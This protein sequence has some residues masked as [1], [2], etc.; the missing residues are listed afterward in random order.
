MDCPANTPTKDW[1]H[2]AAGGVDVGPPFRDRFTRQP[3]GRGCNSGS[4]QVWWTG[5]PRRLHH[6]RRK[7]RNGARDFPPKF[8]TA[9]GG[10]KGPPAGCCGPRVSTAERMNHARNC[11]AVDGPPTIARNSSTVYPRKGRGGQVESGRDLIVWDPE[12]DR[13]HH[14]RKKHSGRIRLTNC[15]KLLPAPPADLREMVR[16]ARW[17]GW[18]RR[19]ASGRKRR[20]PLCRSGRRLSGAL[21][22]TRPGKNEGPRRRGAWESGRITPEQRRRS[23]GRGRKTDLWRP[24]ADSCEGRC[25]CGTRS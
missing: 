22:R 17:R 24:G 12:G 10:L 25:S 6:E 3:V 15:S 16:R 2:A 20:R 5:R 1:D 19:P 4:L 21:W 11:P 14:R 23:S 8:P 9:P 18:K 7:K 13:N